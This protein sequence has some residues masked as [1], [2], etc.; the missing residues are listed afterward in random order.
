MNQN[1]FM[2]PDTPIQNNDYSRSRGSFSYCKHI[3]KKE[4]AKQEK[5]AERK[6]KKSKATKGVPNRPPLSSPKLTTPA[7]S[8]ATS[9]DRF[10]FGM[11]LPDFVKE[12]A[13]RLSPAPHYLY[14]THIRS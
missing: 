7:T 6:K 4:K 3:T 2:A 12:I 10:T 11:K 9:L 1:T 14:P 5:E 8:P 13:A